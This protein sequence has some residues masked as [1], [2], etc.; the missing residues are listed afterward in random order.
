M[1]GE[2]IDRA[3]HVLPNEFKEE[4]KKRYKGCLFTAN[5]Y[6]KVEAD[7]LEEFFGINNLT[8]DAEGEEDEMLYVS[9]KQV[10]EIYS[11]N[12]KEIHRECV[13]SSD[14]DC[15]ETVNEVLKTL[16]GS[17]C[18]PDNVDSSEP[19]VDSS[20]D[21][22]DSSRNNVD[23]LEPNSDGLNEDNFAKSEPKPAEPKYHIG[24]RVRHIPTRLVDVIDG[25]SQSAPYIYHFK[26]MVDPINGQGIFE[27]DLEPYTEPE[28]SACTGDCPSQ[29]KSQNFDN[30]LKNS[31]S[32]ERRL[33]VAAMAM[34]G[35]LANSHQE[36]IDM[37]IDQV[38][39]L[40]I[41]VTDALLVEVEE[42]GAQ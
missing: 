11:Q 37:K 12:Q 14:K 2:L 5:R 27:S 4:V 35:I 36:M 24:Q 16:F 9:R 1:N 18:L 25:I 21:N 19:N 29:Y 17:K 15:Y 42:G 34:Q 41:E 23:S 13:S 39:K 3:W 32:K 38:V 20:H 40:A 31:F 8:S 26:H 30:I 7:L 33:N 10:Q 28:A 6:A 22:V